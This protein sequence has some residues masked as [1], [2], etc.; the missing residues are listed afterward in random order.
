MKRKLT[1]QDKYQCIR[2]LDGAR[3]TLEREQALY[4]CDALV[5]EYEWLK[6]WAWDKHE[7]ERIRINCEYLTE[8]VG[9]SLGQHRTYQ[10][11]VRTEHKDL[12]EDATD[13]LAL[14]QQL[15]VGRIAWVNW[16]IDELEE[17]KRGSRWVFTVG[18]KE[19]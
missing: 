4:I 18:N 8:W 3:V 10:R 11:W 13:C 17:G 14:D 16:M 9:K 19:Q 12:F 6:I 7:A 1:K 15:K 5:R 2:L